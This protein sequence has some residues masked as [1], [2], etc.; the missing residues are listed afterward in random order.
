MLINHHGVN[1]QSCAAALL[2]ASLQQKVA[3]AVHDVTRHAARAQRVQRVA[4]LL[5]MWVL[6]IVSD[7]GLEQ[8]PEDVERIGAGGPSLEEIYELRADRG[9]QRIQMQIGDEQRVQGG[10]LSAGS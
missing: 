4:D 10:S 9:F 2:E 3:I 8:I 6:I 1:E 7:P 5:P